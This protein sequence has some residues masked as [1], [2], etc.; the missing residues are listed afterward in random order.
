MVVTGDDPGLLWMAKELL[1]TELEEL[2]PFLAG[3][4]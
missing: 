3:L 2:A 1:A 4:S